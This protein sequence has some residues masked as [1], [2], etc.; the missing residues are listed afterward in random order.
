M[1]GITYTRALCAS[2]IPF[3]PPMKRKKSTLNSCVT[4]RSVVPIDTAK[5][6]T[7]KNAEEKYLKKRKSVNNAFPDR[8]L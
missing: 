5:C 3:I 6:L 7:K 4:D 2:V 1:N 8:F